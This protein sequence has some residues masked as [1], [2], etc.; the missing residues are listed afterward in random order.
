MAIG[1]WL[2][3]SKR[4]YLLLEAAAVFVVLM[5]ATLI[6]RHYAG[7]LS[8]EAKISAAKQ[9]LLNVAESLSLYNASYSFYPSAAEIYD[10]KSLANVL[11]SSLRGGANVFPFEFLS[12]ESE[13]KTYSLKV[14]AGGKI[15]ELVPGSMG[16]GEI[17]ETSQ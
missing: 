13:E 1:H 12:Y 8:G 17:I 15:L 10:I 11:S 14:K 7:E 16:V 6:V 2:K 9:R 3:M 4:K 5:N